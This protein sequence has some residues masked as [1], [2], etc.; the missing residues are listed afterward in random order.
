MSLSVLSSEIHNALISSGGEMTPELEQMLSITEA[1][2]PMKIDGY[3]FALDRLKME[4]A[5]CAEKVAQWSKLKHSLDACADRLKDGLKF[6]MKT[7]E[8]TE[9]VGNESRFVLSATKPR[10]VI[11]EAMISELYKVQVVSTVIEKDK[12]RADLDMGLTVPGATYE[13]S[14]ALRAYPAI[15]A[16]AKKK[17][18]VTP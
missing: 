16:S 9:L 3:A 18:A 5:W 17:K 1:T 12:I 13:E 14:C 11:D 4:S 10:L 8:T 15:S 7:M 2:L 6:A